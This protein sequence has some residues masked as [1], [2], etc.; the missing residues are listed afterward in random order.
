MREHERR[1][2]Q[3]LEALP[4]AV[5]TIDAQGR[6]TFFNE[7]SVALAGRR[8]RIGELWCVSWRLFYPDGAPMPHGECP[9]ALTLKENRPIRD[10][11]VIAERPDGTRVRLMP[12]PTPLYDGAGR[13]AGAVNML[14][15]I[16]HRQRAEERLVLLAREVDHRANN[17]LAVVQ[18]TAALTQAETVD[19]YKKLLIG[20]IQALAHAHA[21]L[22]DSRWVGADLRRLV[23]EELAPY[24]KGGERR[25]EIDGPSVMLDPQ[26][27]QSL[28]VAL[29]ELTTNAAKYGSL[30][31]ASGQVRVAW[32]K[33]DGEQLVLRWSEHRGPKVQVPTTRGFGTG[34]V[35]RMLR[36]QLKGEVEHDWRLEGLVCTIKVPLGMA[37]PFRIRTSG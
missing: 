32:R 19:E 17:L 12:F 7:A 29:H 16:T 5:Y 4:A 23:D 22:S 26:L 14:V 20:R 6:I 34:A 31:A 9:M 25:V 33:I 27:G 8:P 3:L 21:L 1:F 10:V 18:A 11:E 36:Y 24:C 13:L 30:S 37:N 15:D 2:R 28:A 35:E